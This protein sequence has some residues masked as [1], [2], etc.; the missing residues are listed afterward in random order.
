MNFTIQLTQPD[1]ISRS[2]P[3]RQLDL[4]LT[5]RRV[6]QPILPNS[7][8]RST[9]WDP[10]YNWLATNLDFHFWGLW[11]PSYNNVTQGKDKSIG[12]AHPENT[13]W[14]LSLSNMQ[15][16]FVERSQ[17]TGGGETID[18]I[19]R[20]SEAVPTMG[21]GFSPRGFRHTTGTGILLQGSNIFVTGPVNWE[22]IP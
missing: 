5:W 17:V 13:G 6:V 9:I 10:K 1:P 4:R 14:R 19:A 8:T 12:H 2:N 16:E 15:L 7:P 18:V 3:P 11:W 22:Y 21:G 20:L